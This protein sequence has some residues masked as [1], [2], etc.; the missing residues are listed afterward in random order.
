M[1][2]CLPTRLWPAAVESPDQDD[3]GA[4]GRVQGEH[5]GDTPAVKVENVAD[6]GIQREVKAATTAP[7]SSSTITVSSRPSTRRP[8][9]AAP[10]GPAGPCRPAP[11]SVTAGPPHRTGAAAAHPTHPRSTRS[12]RGGQQLSATALGVQA[13]DPQVTVGVA[14]GGV[15]GLTLDDCDLR[16]HREQVPDELGR[17]GSSLRS[18][19]WRTFSSRPL[20][21][22]LCGSVW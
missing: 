20:Q 3:D 5:H 17:P 12:P 22:G 1:R 6:D 14:L 4:P 10:P 7:P 21:G 13:D 15:A 19:H 2:A 16:G 18:S 8:R 9:T 11:A